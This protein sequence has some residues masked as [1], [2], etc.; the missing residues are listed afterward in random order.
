MAK[1]KKIE[2]KWKCSGFVGHHFQETMPAEN[3]STLLFPLNNNETLL[4][5]FSLIRKNFAILHFT[6]WK[7]PKCCNW[8]KKKLHPMFE[9]SATTQN[10]VSTTGWF[11][12]VNSKIEHIKMIHLN[13]TPFWFCFWM[14]FQKSCARV[15]FNTHENFKTMEFERK[16]FNWQNKVKSLKCVHKCFAEKCNLSECDRWL[17]IMMLMKFFDRLQKQTVRNCFCKSQKNGS[18]IETVGFLKGHWVKVTIIFCWPLWTQNFLSF[19]RKLLHFLFLIACRK[20]P[21]FV[22]IWLCLILLSVRRHSY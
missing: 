11:F 3:Q 12:I 20:L 6:V 10:L 1:W 19:W 2:K 21:N 13:Q 14:T 22:N 5:C 15:K 4:N 17:L 7:K 16:I 9:C 18:A 8:G